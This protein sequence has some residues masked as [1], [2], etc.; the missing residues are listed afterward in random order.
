MH[1]PRFDSSRTRRCLRAWQWTRQDVSGSEYCELW[2]LDEGWGLAGSVV[3]A[4][5]GVPCLAEYAVETDA[6]WLTREARILLH[7]GGV[8]QSLVLRADARRRWWRGDEEVPQFRGCTDVDLA[9]TPSTNTLPIRRLALEVGQA[10]EVTAAWVRMPDLSLAPL[11]QRYTRLASTRY[12]YES[13]GGSFV[14][15]VETDALGL[16]TRYP[17]AWERVAEA[18]PDTGGGFR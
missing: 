1:P 8:S 3:L 4:E 16:V 11:P 7:R 18:V 5:E 2:E 10:Q 9:F 6:R 15:E 14:A 17:P 12:R 13:T